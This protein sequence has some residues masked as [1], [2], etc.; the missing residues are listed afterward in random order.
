[1]DDTSDFSS[2][3]YDA[4]SVQR[5]EMS[6]MQSVEEDHVVKIFISSA[7]CGRWTRVGLCQQTHYA[8]R[9]MRDVTWIEKALMLL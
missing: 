1:M 2:S 4:V 3:G 6:S 8:S 5:G 9:S 7:F